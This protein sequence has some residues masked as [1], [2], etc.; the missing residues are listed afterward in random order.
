MNLFLRNNQ[1]DVE[2]AGYNET[3]AE[4]RTKGDETVLSLTD[5]ST[6]KL[7]PTEIE[8]FSYIAPIYNIPNR[9]Y[10]VWTYIFVLKII[11]MLPN[12]NPK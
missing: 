7:F 12:V 9:L 8:S 5:D 3:T 4:N 1:C 2:I 11:C 10:I 6:M